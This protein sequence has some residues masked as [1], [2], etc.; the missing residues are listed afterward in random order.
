MSFGNAGKPN[1]GKKEFK[2]KNH[3]DLKSGSLVARILPS[4]GSLRDDPDAWHVYH[5]VHFGYKNKEGKFRPFE[6]PEVSTYDKETKKRTIEVRDAAMDRL[7][8]LKAKLEDTGNRLE[9]AEKAKDEST[10]N[11]LKPLYDKLNKLVGFMGTYNV[12][13]N[14]HMN[15]MLLDGTVGELKIRHKAYL[16]LDVE[17]QKLDKEGIDPVSLNDGRFFVFQRSG[18]GNE[19]NFKVDVY[20]EKV[21]ATV[22]GKVKF[23]EEDKVSFIAGESLKRIE[24]ELFDLD[25]LFEKPTPEE[26]AQ[27]VE[28]S[29]LMTGISPACNVLF[30]DK[31]KARRTASS[32]STTTATVT[33]G[34]ATAT[35]TTK[36]ATSTD[37]SK[38]V[39]VLYVPPTSTV[40]AAVQ[41]DD[42]IK[43][44]DGTKY[45]VQKD[46]TPKTEVVAPK[47][48]VA[49]SLKEMSDEDFFKAMEA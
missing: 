21:E 34:T 36:S 32:T 22:N 25:K 28:S 20:K 19:T 37:T 27:I 10:F 48:T 38:D 31:W 4:F 26:V 2:K 6:S 18:K 41:Y 33:D 46:S 14:H 15:V 42:S 3:F 49:A 17:I 8:D 43:S 12:D 29:D 40:A 23:V 44:S 11:K 24:S 45:A 30:D 1:Y 9:E 13:K 35:T 16:A 39:G 7:V 47:T 5:T